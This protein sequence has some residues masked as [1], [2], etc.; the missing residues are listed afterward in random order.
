[1]GMNFT[2]L[3]LMR[4]CK[5]VR[6]LRVLRV[7][8]FFSVLRVLIS[9][10]VRGMGS[11]FWSMCVLFLLILL[12]G[13][14]MSQVLADYILDEKNPLSTRE[15]VFTHYGGSARATLTMFEATMSGCWPNYSR[16]LIEEVSLAYAVFFFAYISAVGFAVRRGS[17]SLQFDRLWVRRHLL[18]GIHDRR[19][20]LEGD[21]AIHRDDWRRSRRP[22]D[23]AAS[24]A[25][26]QGVAGALWD[27]IFSSGVRCH[28]GNGGEER[29]RHVRRC[30]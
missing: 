26:P 18:P 6:V 30:E 3:R 20:A 14:L 23:L 22:E 16:R 17:S 25:G 15:W 24:S 8:K 10:I 11:L 19:A 12:A 7:F 9:S 27:T 29:A 28:L 1:M 2:M 4:L 13:V 5:L 21:R